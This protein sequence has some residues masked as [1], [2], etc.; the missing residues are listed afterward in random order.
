MVQQS[1]DATNNN[2]LKWRHH[3]AKQF[4]C[5]T[6][7]SAVSNLICDAQVLQLIR[8]LHMCKSDV[9]ILPIY[10]YFADQYICKRGY[11]E[12]IVT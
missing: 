2:N 8:S 11:S 7:L 1:G 10:D 12:E 4:P 3:N 9:P 5:V 6:T